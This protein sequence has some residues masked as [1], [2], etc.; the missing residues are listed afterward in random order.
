MAAAAPRKGVADG[1]ALVTADGVREALELEEIA[2]VVVG[3]T[4]EDEETVVVEFETGF[5]EAVVVEVDQTCHWELLTAGAVPV[6]RTV[7]VFA[8]GVQTDQIGAWLVVVVVTMGTGV[9]VVVVVVVVVF[10][11]G[12]EDQTC[13]AEEVVVVVVVGTGTEEVDQTAH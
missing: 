6:V 11:A 8:A 12:T 2:D 4:E 1:V 9:L 7:V 3:L 5:G 13:H 10:T